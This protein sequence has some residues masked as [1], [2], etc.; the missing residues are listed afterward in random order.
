VKLVEWTGAPSAGASRHLGTTAIETSLPGTVIVVEQRTGIEA[1]GWG[2]ILTRGALMSGI[3]GVI[4]EG[5]AR[6][7]DE[8]T[9]MA[10]PVYARASTT[11]T[12]RGRLAEAATGVEVLVGDVRVRS[13]DWVIADA[14]GVVFIPDSDIEVVL[15]HAEEI[16][17]RESVMSDAV[18]SG[19]P[20]IEV[21]GA[22][23]ER[24]LERH[25]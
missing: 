11:R 24:L 9:E 5:W 21:M 8:A 2:G 25:V 13:D 7:I 17:G 3:A 16:A 10:F 6:D 14:S 19:R 15:A 12:A 4:V 1:A 20:I 23:Y 18:L 22:T